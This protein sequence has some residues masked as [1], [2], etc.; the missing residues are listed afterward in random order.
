M[1]YKLVITPYIDNKQPSC[2]NCCFLKE[3]GI[4]VRSEFLDNSSEHHCTKENIFYHYEIIK[5]KIN[6]NINI[7]IL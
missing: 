7:Q 5:I 1:T 4:C 2:Y 3:K 6:I